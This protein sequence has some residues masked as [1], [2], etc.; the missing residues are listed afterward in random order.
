MCS[1]RFFEFIDFSCIS[2]VDYL[3]WANR[4]ANI[5]SLPVKTLDELILEEAATSLKM[6]A[7]QVQEAINKAYLELGLDEE[8]ADTLS[9]ENPGMQCSDRV[10]LDQWYVLLEN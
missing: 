6:S 5:L 10:F 2:F 4:T 9:E 7:I 3:Y 8:S 1:Q